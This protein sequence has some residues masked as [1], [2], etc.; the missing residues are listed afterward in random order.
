[1]L[2]TL[3]ILSVKNEANHVTY[4]NDIKEIGLTLV[5]NLKQFRGF[6]QVKV[7]GRGGEREKQ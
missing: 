4:G 3:Q 2:N 1:M 6:R 7:G 5:F